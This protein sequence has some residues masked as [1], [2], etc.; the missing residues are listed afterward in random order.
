MVPDPAAVARGPAARA[1]RPCREDA[2]AFR[3]RLAQRNIAPERVDVRDRLGILEY[4]AAIASVDIALET[5]PYNGAT[6]ALDALWMGV[7]LV[8]LAGARAVARGS[9][10]ILRS[11]QLPELIASGSDDYVN[12]DVSLARNQSWRS[13]LRATLRDRLANSPLMD[14][15]TFVADLESAYRQM[16]RAWCGAQRGN[17]S[18][19]AP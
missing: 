4:F 17:H 13:E 1:W 10:S 14:G 11:M 16:W 18:L 3:R 2:G 9:Y 19:A 8:A 5:F 6:T 7:P 12:L 15:P